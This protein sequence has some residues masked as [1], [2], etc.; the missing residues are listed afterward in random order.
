MTIK[1]T[2]A[3]KNGAFNLFSGFGRAF[4]FDYFLQNTEN[5]REIHFIN[6]PP[7]DL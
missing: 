4:A 7:T 1:F 5:N 6:Y 2:V 3:R